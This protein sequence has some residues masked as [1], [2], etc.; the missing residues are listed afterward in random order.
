MKQLEESYNPP[1]LSVGARALSKHAHRSAEWFWGK[2]TGLSE[3]ERN[4]NAFEKLK[5]IINNWVWINIH[6]LPHDI[7]IIEWRIN[8]QVNSL[9]YKIIIW[10]SMVFSISS[11]L[12]CSTKPKEYFDM[13]SIY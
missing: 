8:Y 12:L 9:K 11:L 2:V 3:E 6:G 10:Q 13:I 7:V 1:K 5:E 4:K